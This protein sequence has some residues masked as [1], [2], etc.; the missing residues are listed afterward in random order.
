MD[1]AA[2]VVSA[3][4]ATLIAFSAAMKLTHR[5]AVVESYREAG[6]P[7]SWLNGLAALLLLAAAGLVVG[8][9]WPI[10]GIAASIGLV[11][12]FVLAVGFHVR[13]NDTAHVV[14]PAVLVVLAAAAVV[15]GVAEL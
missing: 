12:Y 3:V 7:E 4:L 1:I 10:A 8:I 9:W 15:L 2:V 11:A 5:P 13:A 14:T 6:V